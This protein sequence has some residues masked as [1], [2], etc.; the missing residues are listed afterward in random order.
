[1]TARE[2]LAGMFPSRSLGEAVADEIL[3]EHR[4]ELAEE[5][6]AAIDDLDSYR[7]G[8]HRDRTQQW[9]DGC[10]DGLT[11]AA[12]LVRRMAAPTTTQEQ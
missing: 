6:A 5:F 12:V 11:E 2:K 8:E 4:A 10:S 9:L 7:P 3:A 1:M